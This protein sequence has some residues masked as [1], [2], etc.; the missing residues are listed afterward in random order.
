MKTVL[1]SIFNSKAML[2]LMINIVDN[3]IG[4]NL[5]VDNVIGDNMIG[6]NL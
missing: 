5:I 1:K 6:D 4:D 3:V 2:A